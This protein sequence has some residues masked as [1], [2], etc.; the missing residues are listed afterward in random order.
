MIDT[1][2]IDMD[3]VAN[4]FHKHVFDFFQI[5]Y[6]DN[7][8][9]PVECGWDIISAAN[10]L[11]G[12][13]RFTPASFWDAIPREIWSSIPLSPEFDFIIS[14]AEIQVGKENVHFL[15][16]PTLSP[17]CLAGKLDWIQ[18]FA[19]KW[20]QRQFLIGPSKHL[21]AKTTT[22]LID[23]SDKNVIKFEGCGGQA[24]LV[25]RPWNSLHGHDPI[26]FLGEQ[27]K[28]F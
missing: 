22:L 23:D 16:S 10:K 4:T 11:A 12:Y 27:F 19:P 7:S 18:S 15:T 1:I 6:S 2:L 9:Y 24:I 21:C 28:R 14:W 25:P 13:E 17:E 8:S 5:P 20:M 3:G 26:R